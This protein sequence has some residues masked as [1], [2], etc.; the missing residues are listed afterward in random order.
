MMII[1][2]GTKQSSFSS[3]MAQSKKTGD[4]AEQRAALL[5]GA[6]WTQ[7]GTRCHFAVSAK[8]ASK[9]PSIPHLAVQLATTGLYAAMQRRA[10]RMHLMTAVIDTVAARG[11]IDS[12][13]RCLLGLK[14][15]SERAR[16]LTADTLHELAARE[17]YKT[18]LAVAHALY[19]DV[20]PKQD[21]LQLWTDRARGVIWLA[22]DNTV[23]VAEDW[24]YE[25]SGAGS[26]I[27]DLAM[28]MCRGNWAFSPATVTAEEYADAWAR[29]C[30]QTVQLVEIEADGRLSEPDPCTL[31][32][33]RELWCD[34]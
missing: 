27:Q 9:V 5:S 20:S 13:A 8:Q 14:E 21:V 11:T 1:S 24:C 26:W 34:D 3:Q 12:A 10:D 2:C 7:A 33:L 22:P 23:Y 6:A 28:F 19:P 25:P 30:E 31:A 4:T 15:S 29:T 17:D 16:M 18:C 32:H